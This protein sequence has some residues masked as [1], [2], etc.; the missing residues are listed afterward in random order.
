MVVSGHN[1]FVC[2]EKN[3]AD[4]AEKILLLEALGH[5]KISD[6]GLNGRQ[7]VKELFSEQVIVSEYM[8]IIEK[9]T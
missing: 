1:G 5:H 7:R 4:L 8:N 3:S 6:L 9:V 2:Q